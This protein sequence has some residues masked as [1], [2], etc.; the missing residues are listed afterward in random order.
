MLT[1]TWK[2][3]Q[4]NGFM[5]IA[6]IVLTIVMALMFNDYLPGIFDEEREMLATNYSMMLGIFVHMIIFS[7]L[8][9]NEKE[10]EQSHGYEFMRSLPIESWQIVAGKY[11][12]AICYAI[13]AIVLIVGV[14]SIFGVKIESKLLPLAYTLFCAGVGLV[15]VGGLY[16]LA[17]KI[18]Y[19][20]L[21]PVV[22]IVY[23]IAMMSPQIIHL[24]LLI[25][26]KESTV[27]KLF[28]G[29]TMMTGGII[30]AVGLIL[31]AGLGVLAV[32]VKDKIPVP[33]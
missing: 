23:I 12:A 10:E 27:E 20:K 31:F 7:G 4:K 1:I 6:F 2:E 16:L 25:N 13:Y 8:M 24:L 28:S 9:A 26:E 22:M 30:F 18:R 14:T 33:N 17:F 11:L 32:R 15:L 3:I 5:F 21:I 19:T 29:L